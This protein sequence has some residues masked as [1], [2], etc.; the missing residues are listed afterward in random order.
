MISMTEYEEII[1]YRNK[2]FTQEE[3]SV[4]IE[5]SLRTVGRYLS[6]GKIPVYKRTKPTKTDPFEKYKER[7]EEIIK[8][9]V[10][11]K[12]V[13]AVDL[14]RTLVKE[15]YF[16]SLRTLQRKTCEL[17]RC[18][19]NKEIYFEQEVDY[20]EMIE[21]DFTDI[22]IPFVFGKEARHLWTMSSKKVKGCYATSFINQTFESFAEGTAKG[23]TFFG[24]VP[25]IYRLDNLKPA[26]K[27]ILRKGRDT[28]DKFNQL[29]NYYNFMPSF[30]APAKGNEKGT[31]ESINKH[32]KLFLSYEIEIDNKVF[33]D[34]LDFEKYLELKT[35]EYNKTKA[36]EQ[37]K[38]KSF[39]LPLPQEPFPAFST[40]I[41]E[42]NKYGFVLAA[43]RRYSVPEQYK[44]RQV[45]IRLYSKRI[46]I[47]L[48]GQKIKEHTR[49]T[50]KGPRKPSIDFMDHVEAMLRKPGAF[51][52]YKH[53]DSFFPTEVFKELYYRN[54]DNKK[55]LTCLSQCKN[56]SIAE[57]E[58]AITLSTENEEKAPSYETILKLLNPGKED[59]NAFTDLKPLEPVLDPYDSLLAIIN[60]KGEEEWMQH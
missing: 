28:T 26:V 19:K 44:F 29:R 40:E 50:N 37:N 15:G 45:E 42:V 22:E 47:F 52:Y 54:P 12:P 36:D 11:G 18:S 58:L 53:K 33:N 43:G 59:I 31:I 5:R 1:K 2:G 9:G 41:S 8:K 39:F 6:S 27:R 46:E 10:N 21:G 24:G 17:R 25:K 51:T 20:G 14:F 23:F 60:V 30:C 35:A 57:V 16:G 55:Y 34:D 38:E 7:A 56:H 4:L 49:Q 32:F 48:N 3:I 13:R